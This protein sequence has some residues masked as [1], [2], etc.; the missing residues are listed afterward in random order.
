[1]TEPPVVCDD[2]LERNARLWA[3]LRSIPRMAP[4]RIVW[5]MVISLLFQL[6]PTMERV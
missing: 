2:G 1:V 3:G 6:S 5:R 4:R